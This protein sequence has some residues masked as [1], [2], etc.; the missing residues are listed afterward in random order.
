MTNN[1]QINL[2]DYVSRSVLQFLIS[3]DTDAGYLSIIRHV[4]FRRRNR[5]VSKGSSHS[6]VISLSLFVWEQASFVGQI[7]P[8]F[9]MEHWLDFYFIVAPNNP[10]LTNN[11][12]VNIMIFLFRHFML[13][14][15][16]QD[17]NMTDD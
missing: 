14:H 10:S 1:S 15:N 6:Q 9:I 3:R 11:K 13:R 2:T 5:Q 16:N 4:K 7:N 8:H 12:T 17:S